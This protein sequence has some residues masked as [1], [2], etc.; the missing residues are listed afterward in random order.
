VEDIEIISYIII[1]IIIIIISV[2]IGTIGGGGAPAAAE[3]SYLYLKFPHS[4]CRYTATSKFK[5]NLS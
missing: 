5:S 4:Q 2:T 3:L 1:I